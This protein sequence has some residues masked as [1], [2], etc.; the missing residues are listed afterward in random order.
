MAKKGY[1][2]VTLELPKKKKLK[3]YTSER[4][5]NAAKEVLERLDTLYYATRFGQVIEAAF[6]HGRK[7]GVREVFEQLD[8]LKGTI[9]HKLPG[10][11]KGH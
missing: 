6:E 10:R 5:A 4:I 8:A 2:T 3:L 7:Q 9:P 1:R 11:P